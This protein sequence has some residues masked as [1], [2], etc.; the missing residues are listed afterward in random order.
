MSEP[1][2]WLMLV[3]LVWIAGWVTLSVCVRHLKGKPIFP[4]APPGS[5]FVEKR[6]SGRSLRTIWTRLGGANKCLL[7]A[8]T[9]ESLLVTP[10]FPFN[11]MFLP[12]IYDLDFEVPRSEVTSIK[13]KTGLLGESLLIV[14]GPHEIEL[15]LRQPDNFRRALSS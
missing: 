1:P 3:P 9:H 14:A 5:L 4:K 6:G 11:L 10:Q 8:V 2:A 15:R 7:V 12:E 13:T